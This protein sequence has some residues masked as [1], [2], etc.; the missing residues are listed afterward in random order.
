MADRY[1]IISQ[2]QVLDT[3]DVT[4]P[5]QAMLITF[6]TPTQPGPFSVTIPLTQYSAQSVH[7]AI[8]EYVGNIEDVS[9][10]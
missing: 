2:T 7:D 5:Q 9:Q 4:N 6:R 3:R 1:T 8:T 10:L